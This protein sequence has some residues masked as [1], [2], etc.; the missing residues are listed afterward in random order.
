[1]RPTR[2]AWLGWL[3]VLG[4]VTAAC[5]TAARAGA[6]TWDDERA[7]TLRPTAAPEPALLRRDGPGRYTLSRA[8]FEDALADPAALADTMRF[9]PVMRH[10]S[11][12]GY[13]ALHVAA[14]S[15]LAG[16]L[17][18]GDVIERI[19][20]VSL[21]DSKASLELLARIGE[22]DRFTIEGRRAARPLSVVVRIA[23]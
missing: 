22:Q 18:R 11:V 4:G 17:E 9:V 16:V 19:N 6:T 15:P 7:H 2:V 3:L 14:A 10:K 8:A 5:I 12:I 21:A 13:R 1:M 23:R 20:G